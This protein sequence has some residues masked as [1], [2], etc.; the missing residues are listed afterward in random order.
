MLKAYA[1]ITILLLLS[2][3]G[4]RRVQHDDDDMYMTRENFAEGQADNP[5]AGLYAWQGNLDGQ[6]PVL[7]WYKEVDSVLI[8][9][10]FYTAQKKPRP[11]KL[12]GEIRHGEHHLDEFLPDGT[13]TGSWDMLPARHSIEGTWTDPANDKSYSASLMETDTA[14]TIAGYR[15]NMDVSGVYKYVYEGN[16]PLGNLEVKQLNDDQVVLNINCITRGP[17]YNM[18]VI[19]N[20]TAA[21]HARTAG[22]LSNEFG[23]CQFVIRFFEDFAKISYVDMKDACGFGNRARVDGIYLK[24]K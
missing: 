9:T 15:D 10:L 3:C 16:G 24:E 6:Y 4:S 12:I 5:Y 23:D 8:G 19:Q 22:Y 11:I 13:I 7:M 21:L 20:D 17:A 18:A 1:Y 14:V 2:A